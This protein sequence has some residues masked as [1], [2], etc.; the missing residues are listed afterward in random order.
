MGYTRIFS[1]SFSLA[2]LSSGNSRR[3]C[4]PTIRH[5]EGTDGSWGQFSFIADFQQQNA[6]SCS[7]ICWVRDRGKKASWPGLP[8][9]PR[10]AASTSPP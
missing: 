2:L 9:H 4:G 5:A 7:C 1:S 8:G 3:S 10:T 6:G